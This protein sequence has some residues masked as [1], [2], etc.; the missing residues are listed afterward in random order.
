VVAHFCQGPFRFGQ[1][2]RNDVLK[3]L[4]LGGQLDVACA[5]REKLHAEVAFQVGNEGAERA[6]RQTT[7]LGRARETAQCRQG[8]EG[9]HVA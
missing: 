7:V 1:Q 6:L 8:R 5:A 3:G 2:V 9:L 4:A